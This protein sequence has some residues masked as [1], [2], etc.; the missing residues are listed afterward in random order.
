MIPFNVCVE[1]DSD[2]GVAGSLVAHSGGMVQRLYGRSG[3]AQ[4]LKRIAGY[5]Q[6]AVRSP[7]LVIV[8][9]DSDFEQGV[10]AEVAWLPTSSPGMAFVVAVREIE[11]WILGDAERVANFLGV[12]RDKIPL[13]P[14]S[15]QDPKEHLIN[16]ATASRYRAIREGLVPRAGSR[17]SVG[18]LY[19][20]EIRR[21]GEEAWRPE[22][23]REVCPSLDRM[24]NRLT[25]VMDTFRE[26][27]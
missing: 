21:F 17:A 1:G 5:N 20:S 19:A 6:A 26:R 15:L 13:A 11:S 27:S 12:S 25:L 22:V 3:K 10:D 14:E 8:D 9:L 2:V 4:V 16:L 23:A 24:L 7:W 18:P